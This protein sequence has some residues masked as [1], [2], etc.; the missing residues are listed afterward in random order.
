MDYDYGSVIDQQKDVSLFLDETGEPAAQQ[1]DSSRLKIMTR[2]FVD[3]QLTLLTFSILMY[4]TNF[5][6]FVK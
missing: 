2:L 3:Q 1:R 5:M 6:F 4:Q